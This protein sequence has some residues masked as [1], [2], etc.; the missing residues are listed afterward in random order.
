MTKHDDPIGPNF[1]QEWWQQQGAD[2]Q[3]PIFAQVATVGEEKQPQVR[4]VHVRYLKE[5]GCLGI[6]TH[7][8]SKKWQALAKNPQL[9]GCYFDSTNL[10]QFRWTGA[11]KLI[12][13]DNE[14]EKGFLDLM[15]SLLDEGVRIGYWVIPASN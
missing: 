13:G 15:W 3:N 9:A 14:K 10:H 5:K 4:T 6:N 1:L 12:E 2:E 8:R 7:V 11:V